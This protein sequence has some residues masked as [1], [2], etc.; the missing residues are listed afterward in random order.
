MS[1]P[2]LTS[3]FARWQDATVSRK[4]VVP[5]SRKRVVNFDQMLALCQEYKLGH[6]DSKW[7]FPSPVA[8]T[9]L[10]KGRPVDC[11]APSRRSKKWGPRGHCM[12][13]GHASPVYTSYATSTRCPDRELEASAE[14]CPDRELEASA[15]EYPDKE[16]KASVVKEL[17]P[18]AQTIT[19][20]EGCP[21]RELE[22]SVEEFMGPNEPRWRFLDG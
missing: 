21:D 8:L 9:Q 18:P 12:M 11:R 6:K 15:E 22:T 5:I 4:P 13:W 14:E 2:I 20:V 17:G 1:Q 3:T 10:R 7:S 19:S 16:L